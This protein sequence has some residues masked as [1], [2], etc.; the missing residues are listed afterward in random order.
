M[1]T[2][3][4][5]LSAALT[6]LLSAQQFLTQ[7]IAEYDKKL[8]AAESR[9]ADFK[10]H[11]AGLVPGATGGDARYATSAAATARTAAIASTARPSRRGPKRPVGVPRPLRWVRRRRTGRSS[12]P[13]KLG[14]GSKPSSGAAEGWAESGA[15]MVTS[16]AVELSEEVPGEAR[17]AGAAG[18]RRYQPTTKLISRP[19]TTMTFRT[20]VSS[21][22]AATRGSARA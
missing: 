12:G 14:S 16:E 2:G 9:L 17:H 11:N 22:S 5:C 20:D 1:K 7:Q 21:S 10:R 8:A 4:F 18:W 13:Q 3:I 6:V 19:G 15:D